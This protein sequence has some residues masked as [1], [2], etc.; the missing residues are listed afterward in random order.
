MSYRV[1]VYF[2]SEYIASTRIRSGS[3]IDITRY[4][5]DSAYIA[6]GFT[7]S[8]T[9]TATPADGCEFVKWYYRIGGDSGALQESTQNPFTYSGSEEIIIRAVGQPISG[10]GSG[11]SDDDDTPWTACENSRIN[12]YTDEK[13]VAIQDFTTGENILSPYQVHRYPVK[14]SHSG[15]AHFYTTGDVDTIG[16]LSTTSTWKSDFSRPSSFVAFDDN[17]YD[18]TNFDIRYY[19]NANTVYYIYVRG[20][21]GKESGYV[22]LCITEPWELSSSNLGT[23]TA[24]QSMVIILNAGTMWCGQ[25]SFDSNCKVTVSF[26]TTMVMQCWISKSSGWSHGEPTSYIAY[27]D[28]DYT[29]TFDAVA[30]QTY[31]IW[32]RDYSAASSGQVFLDITIPETSIKKWSWSASNG[33]AYASETS[34][35]YKAVQNKQSTK[36][37][38]HLVWNDM[39]D[40]TKAICDKAVGWWDSESYGLDYAN[41]K[42][43]VNSNGEY[44]LTAEMFN[45]LRNNLEIAGYH[46]LG[47]AK[48]PATTNHDN[49]PNG[50]IPHPVVSGKTVFGHYFITLADYMN[51]CIDK[52]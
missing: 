3:F 21:T 45:S 9:F 15:Y 50:T 19:V 48:I 46:K 24:T 40:K 13:V 4:Y 26:D 52:L 41:T 23:L 44:E 29:I 6:D 51:S 28:W 27:D 31:Y 11:G 5:G 25:V 17:S 36:N 16:Y 18:G 42:A 38:S 49:A 2:N 37:F 35:A 43:K 33:N 8:T 47:L 14:F 34:A 32:F 30:G 20:S 12:V 39:V 10:G 22:D 1:N 7:Y